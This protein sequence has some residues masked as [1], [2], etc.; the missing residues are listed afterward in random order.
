MILVRVSR[1]SEG[2]VEII[3]ADSGPGV[4]VEDRESIFDAYYSTRDSGAGLGLSIVGEI[5]SNYYDGGLELLESSELP[6]ASFRI[7]LRKRV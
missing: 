7:I 6:G 1:T 4:P 3:F 2:F 5:I